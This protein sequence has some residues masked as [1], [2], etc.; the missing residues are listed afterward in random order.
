MKTLTL[1]SRVAVLAALFAL[2]S[3][4]AAKS[5]T[6]KVTDPKGSPMGGVM[7]SAFD[8]EHRKWISVFS[9][10]DGSFTIDGLR[11]I[12]H[13]VRA[14]LMGKVDEWYDD[15]KPGRDTVAIKMHPA[16]GLDL[17]EQ[18]PANSGFSML[19]FDNMR[20]KLNFKMMCSYC[21]QIG[22]IPI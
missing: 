17:E 3:P 12:Q 9:Q 19:K 21:H 2:V 4:V 5:L 11:D 18:R 10:K 8:E 7:V 13:Q 22:T 1:F 16:S 20:D 6:G 14:R 15:V